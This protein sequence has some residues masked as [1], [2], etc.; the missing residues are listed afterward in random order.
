[1][2]KSLH[3]LVALI[4]IAL[5]SC[6]TSVRFDVEHPP[7][8][9]LRGVNSITVIPFEN[10]SF[11]EFEY[12]STHLTSALASGIRNSS[13]RG[14]FL[15]IEPQMLAHVPQRNLWQY[16]DVFV[17]GRIIDI[18]SNHTRSVSSQTV[19]G[20]EIN[21][22]TITLTVTVYIEYSYVRA[23]DGR[24]L[25]IFRKNGT[26]SE[27]ANWV[28]RRSNLG[29]GNRPGT[30]GPG[31]WNHPNWNRPGPWNNPGWFDPD[32]DRGDRGRG[33]R[34]R[35]GSNFPRRNTWEENL[36]RSA[37]ERFSLSM[38]H[39]TAPWTTMEERSLRRIR[40]EPMLDEARRLVRMGRYEQAL[41]IYQEIYEQNGSVTI[42]FNTAILLAANEKFKE[43]LELLNS[44][45]R[46]L[47]ALNQ[48]PP[49]FLR[50][51]M[52][53]MSEVVNG[54]RILEEL[55]ASRTAV[56]TGVNATASVRLLGMTVARNRNEQVH[57]REVNGTVNLNLAK[58]Y[59]LSESIAYAEDT[60]IWSK[61]VAS[62]DADALEG[63]WSMR[64]PDTAPALLWFVVV[65]GRYNL[66]ITQMPLNIS[67]AIV[68]DTAWMTRLE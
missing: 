54:L 27:T 43:A 33:R 52:Q 48:T 59:A 4:P 32:R 13:L 49:R 9:D 53:R 58:I 5:A 68:L 26:F 56:G 46:G 55:R 7:I 38:S 17:D 63:R 34:G 61:I 62:T 23:R 14:N 51:E 37:I 24:V 40:N 28:R 19:G 65:D 22:V 18:R 10:H 31:T 15:F 35:S 64:I 66:F 67:E 47:L 45:H 20:E 3:F 44:L 30:W 12:L 21:I 6:A 41:Q 16:V 60:S 1:V 25:K 2:I 8:V 50:R 42:G 11:R 29:G 57:A 36:A 39:E